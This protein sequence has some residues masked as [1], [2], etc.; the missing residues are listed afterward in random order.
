MTLY[1]Q[2]FRFH[3]EEIIAEP[4]EH[5]DMETVT[6]SEMDRAIVKASDAVMLLLEG[7]P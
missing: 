3:L 1:D 4:F 7:E 2:I 5:L 6:R